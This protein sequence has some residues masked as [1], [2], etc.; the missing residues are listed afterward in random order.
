MNTLKNK[1]NKIAEKTLKQKANET[2]IDLSIC[3]VCKKKIEPKEALIKQTGKT[4]D[5]IFNEMC[6]TFDIYGNIDLKSELGIS[7]KQFITNEYNKYVKPI[8]VCKKCN[9]NSILNNKQKK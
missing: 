9:Q 3:S 6:E 5:E 8:C 4:Y 1:F 2:H 7:M